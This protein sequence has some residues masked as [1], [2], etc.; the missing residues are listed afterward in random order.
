MKLKQGVILIVSFLISCTSADRYIQDDIIPVNDMKVIVW[1]IMQA[2]EFAQVK[3][4][5]DSTLIHHK[6][7]GMFQQVFRLH[8]TDKESFYK[9]FQYYQEH[10]I[11]N[12]ILFDSV[13]A[14][15]TRQRQELYKKKQ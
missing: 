14:Y 7:I 15:A 8:T 10:P 5:K 6:S 11:L 9:S 13:S 2:S 12:K 3:Y 4:G 1:D